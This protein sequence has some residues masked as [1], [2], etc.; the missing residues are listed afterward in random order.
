MQAELL[1]TLYRDVLLDCT[2]PVVDKLHSGRHM[3][4]QKENETKQDKTS[5]DTRGDC[6]R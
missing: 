5:H 1:V 3:A 4:R 2:H 6:K